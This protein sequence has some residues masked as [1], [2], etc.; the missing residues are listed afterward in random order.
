MLVNDQADWMMHFLNHYSCLSQ[1]QKHRNQRKIWTP[2]QKETSRFHQVDLCQIQS[3]DVAIGQLGLSLME[4]S[5]DYL[6]S[7]RAIQLLK[8]SLPEEDFEGVKS[9]LRHDLY[10]KV[11]LKKIISYPLDPLQK[12]VIYVQSCSQGSFGFSNMSN[13]ST[14]T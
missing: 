9:N 13:T 2:A 6:R 3:F 11:Y 7:R 4:A 5:K 10:L 12:I 1:A 14:F 8:C